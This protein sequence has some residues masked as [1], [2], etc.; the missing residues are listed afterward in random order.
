MKWVKFYTLIFHEEN[1]GVAIT[2]DSFM[3]KIAY[4]EF[5]ILYIFLIF[6]KLRWPYLRNLVITEKPFSIFPVQTE[7][8]NSREGFLIYRLENEQCI[9][10]VH[11]CT[12]VSVIID[13]MV[14]SII[15]GI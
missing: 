2:I 5:I 4:N 3:R 6:C 8:E 10:L 14:W 12:L 7:L 11:I 15:I 9:W 13:C 1:Y